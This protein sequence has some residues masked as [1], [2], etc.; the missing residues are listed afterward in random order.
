MQADAPYRMVPD[1]LYRWYVRSVVRRRWRRSRPSPRYQLDARA[2]EARAL[3]RRRLAGDPGHAR[4]GPKLGR[5]DGRSRRSCSSNCRR[6]SAWN[7]PAFPIRSG[8]PARR[9]M[10]S[11]AISVLVVFLLLAALY[12]SWSIPLS[13]MLVIPLGIVGA[14]LAATLRGPLQ[15]HLFPG[16]PAH[17]DGPVG[18]ERDPDRRVRG[19]CA[20]ARRVDPRCGA[21][22][23]RGCGCGRS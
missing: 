7:G 15:R 17:H 22:K 8:R 12:E 4:A 20:E 19:R 16:R 21:S 14:V 5:G 11:T 13:V 1:D 6:A 18:Q 23:A 2:R 10:R 3:Q 9:P